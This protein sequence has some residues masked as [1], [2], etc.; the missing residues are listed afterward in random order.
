MLNLE[1]IGRVTCLHSDWFNNTQ[2]KTTMTQ[3]LKEM[4]IIPDYEGREYQIVSL[5]DASEPH[6]VGEPVI[7]YKLMDRVGNIIDVMDYEL[8]AYNH[9]KGLK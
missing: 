2:L 1:Q 7:L 9:K 4:D 3:Q 6:T 5:S 8:A